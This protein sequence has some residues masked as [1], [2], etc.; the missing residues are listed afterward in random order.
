MD[1]INSLPDVQQQMFQRLVEKLMIPNNNITK[2]INQKDTDN[3]QKLIEN[4][5]DT[6]KLINMQAIMEKIKENNHVDVDDCVEDNAKSGECLKKIKFWYQKSFYMRNK[7]CYPSD[8]LG[9]LS[10][11]YVSACL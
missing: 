8:N 2:K 6:N 9:F 4:L 7:S 11:K 1:I 10:L 3:I 5:R